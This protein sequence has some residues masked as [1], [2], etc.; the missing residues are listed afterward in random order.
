MSE[1][2]LITGGA[3]DLGRALARAFSDA[4][5][6]AGTGAA[7]R[8]Q[9]EAP[10]RDELDVAVAG[11]VAAYFA[12]RPAFDLVIANAGIIEDKLVARLDDASWSRVLEVNL[13][14]AARCA[15]A[16]LPAMCRAR[17]GHLVFISSHS[18]IHPPAGQAA[19]ATAK[20]GLLGLMSSLAREA[21]PFGI[22]SNAVLPGFLETR[23]TA[24]LSPQRREQVRG[25][26]SLGRFNTADCVAAFIRHLH[27]DLPHTSGQT[28]RLDSRVG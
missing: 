22:R 9:V 5:G 14:G 18:A 17:R 21:G 23:M 27:R 11:S 28:F 15:R 19:Y 7:D 8:D 10:G 26:H 20:A 2:I 13:H 25:E 3:G 6:A 24:G 16:A 12:A 1:R 4:S